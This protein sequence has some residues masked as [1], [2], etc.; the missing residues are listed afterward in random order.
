MAVIIR[1]SK[2]HAQQIRSATVRTTNGNELQRS[3]NQL[4][5]LEIIVNED[6]QDTFEPRPLRV[7]PPR[8]VKRRHTF[9][10]VFSCESNEAYVDN[11]VVN[12]VN[13]N[14]NVASGI[15][16]DYDSVSFLLE[17][18]LRFFLDFGSAPGKSAINIG[19]D[20]FEYC[21][22]V[23]LFSSPIGQRCM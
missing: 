18:Q 5:P 16:L 9:I 7:Q 23:L 2:D 20:F 14:D 3:I 4:Y 6:P 22:T 15:H 12:Y 13:S 11:R 1:L 17:I 19:T 21:S 10:V 8:A